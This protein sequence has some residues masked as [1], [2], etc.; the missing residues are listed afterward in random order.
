VKT[1]SSFDVVRRRIR[2]VLTVHT[3]VVPGNA[4]CLSGSKT[5]LTRIVEYN[6]LVLCHTELIIVDRLIQ[7]SVDLRRQENVQQTLSLVCTTSEWLSR[8]FT[9]LLTQLMSTY[10]GNYF[11]LPT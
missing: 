5:T 11:W 6:S 10:Y 1:D 9:S 3:L 4:R 8:E 7:I 2:P